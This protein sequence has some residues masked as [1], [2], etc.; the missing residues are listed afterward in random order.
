M[1][2]SS[3][4]R[5]RTAATADT[6]DIIT[7]QQN[8][9]APGKNIQDLLESFDDDQDLNLL[10]DLERVFSKRRTALQYAQNEIT[11]LQDLIGSKDRQ[12]EVKDEEIKTLK[13]RVDEANKRVTK[14]IALAQAN[15]EIIRN[16]SDSERTVGGQKSCPICISNSSII[17]DLQRRNSK[18]S[19]R[20]IESYERERKLEKQLKLKTDE[21]EIA[22]KRAFREGKEAGRAGSHRGSGHSDYSLAPFSIGPGVKDTDNTSSSSEDSS[23]GSEFDEMPTK[24]QRL[25]PPRH[26]DERKDVHSTNGYRPGI[27]AQSTAVSPLP[28]VAGRTSLPSNASSKLGSNGHAGTA[29]DYAPSKKFSPEFLRHLTGG[30]NQLFSSPKDGTTVDKQSIAWEKLIMINLACQPL[31][32][33]APHESGSIYLVDGEPYCTNTCGV[34]PTVLSSDRNASFSYI[35]NCDVTNSTLVSIESWNALSPS[36]QEEFAEY[37]LGN[38]WGTKLLL[39]KNLLTEITSVDMEGKIKEVLGFFSRHTTPNL[40]MRSY[41][42]RWA[43]FSKPDYKDLCSAWET[44]C[45]SDEQTRKRKREA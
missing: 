39:E 6:E 32:P 29:S 45:T 21:I 16:G 1:G 35:G 14:A 27:S 17:Q 7:N 41:S 30:T 26:Q 12:T 5:R 37:V 42:L 44:F 2:V 31:A 23:T 24:R 9:D 22:K 18:N 40:R 19:D 34:Y 13:L 3:T 43:F 15:Q 8:N 36:V 10:R 20:V 38:A 33:K 11:R 28:K 4:S 25:A